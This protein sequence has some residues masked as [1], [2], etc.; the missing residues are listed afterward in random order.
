[1]TRVKICGITNLDDALNAVEQ[2]ADAIG[3]VFAP[4][5]R[6]INEEKAR[7]IREHV[8]PFVSV[9][10]VFVNSEPL[11]VRKTAEELGL[12]FVQIYGTD[13]A[14]FLKESGMNP[15]RLIQAVSVASEADLA[16]IERTDAATILLDTKVEGKAGGTGKTFDWRIAARAKAYGK[17]IVLS[18]GLNPDNVMRAIEI[19]SPHA[20]DVS[21]GVEASPG[22]KDPGKVREF[23][24]RA[25][26][27][28]A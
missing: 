22:K 21:S 20:V 11:L 4:S 18:G 19:A 6:Q 1:M 26:G 5:V 3:F 12:D 7:A 23:I 10:G 13:S 15:R 8:P 28:V 2:G 17:P 9:V 24:R 14:R 16:A 25:K 27:Y